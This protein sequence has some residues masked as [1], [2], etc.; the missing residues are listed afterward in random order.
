ML[1]PGNQILTQEKVDNAVNMYPG[2]ITLKQVSRKECQ[3]MRGAHTPDA[4][5]K[6]T[7][8]EEA[9]TTH[10]RVAETRINLGMQ[11]IK[12]R[13][14]HKVRRPNLIIEARRLEENNRKTIVCGLI[15]GGDTR[16]RLIAPPIEKPMS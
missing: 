12:K 7:K 3:R 4:G 5:G 16:K 6:E 10:S 2:K 1:I 9:L 14:S 15:E 13:T 11:S 8:E